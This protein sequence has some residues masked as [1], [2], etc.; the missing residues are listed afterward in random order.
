MVHWRRW[1][2]GLIL[3]PLLVL[4]IVKGGRALFVLLVLLANGL[5]QW[6]FLAMLLP[7]SERARRIK[8]IVLGSLLI[9][10][11]CTVQR[12]GYLC[13]PSGPLFILVWCLFILM[14]FY[15]VSYGHIPELSRDLAVN[16]MG[17]LYLPLLLGHLVWLRF[18]PQGQW[19]VIWMLAVVFGA[20]TAAFYTGLSLGRRKLYPAVSPGKTW[21]GTLGGLAAAGVVGAAAGRW[22]LPEA[23][24][25]SL[26]ALALVLGGVGV[27]GDLFESMLKRQ[28]Q[29]KDASH[30]LPGHGG[31]LDRLDSVLFAAPAVV[32]ARLFFM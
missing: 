27:L 12:I 16:A 17:L 32:Y 3:A 7:G 29:V 15:L 6:E 13:N 31:M 2:T 1:L 14:L 28:A 19:W 18:L 4:V 10:S 8:L 20:D 23:K 30:L 22:L 26:T 9:I 5:G 25:G 11:F 21:E 24:I